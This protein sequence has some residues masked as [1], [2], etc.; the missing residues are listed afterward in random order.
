MHFALLSLKHYQYIHIEPYSLFRIC[1]YF[2][3]ILPM[4]KACAIQRTELFVSV[5]QETFLHA[6][7]FCATDK[8]CATEFC[9]TD[10]INRIRFVF[11]FLFFFSSVLCS[12]Y[13]DLLWLL[14]LWTEFCI[15]LSSF[16]QLRLQNKTMYHK[17]AVS[18]K[19]CL[20]LTS[21]LNF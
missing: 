7:Y 2:L 16:P 13:S 18:E 9:A 3:L 19:C 15:V 8:F 5:T 4:H 11:L 6:L 21:T 17:H 14:N 12:R 10:K 20:P 1:N